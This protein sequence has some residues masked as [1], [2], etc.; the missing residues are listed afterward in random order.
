MDSPK[1]LRE[2]FQRL[3]KGNA[4]FAMALETTDMNANGSWYRGGDKHP[5]C[6]FGQ[7]IHANLNA[8]TA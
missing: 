8:K 2:E 6:Q 3:L 7:N 4:L 1:K 5:L